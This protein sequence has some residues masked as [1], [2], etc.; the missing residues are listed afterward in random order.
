MPWVPTGV[1]QAYFRGALRKTVQKLQV[2]NCDPA[3]VAVQLSLAKIIMDMA[4]FLQ[5]QV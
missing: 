5:A 3:P 2:R 4:D 1:R